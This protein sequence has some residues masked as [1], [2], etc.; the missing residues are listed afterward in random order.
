MDPRY[1]VSWNN[2]QAPGWAAADDQYDYGPLHRQQMIADRVRASIRGSH[3]ASLAQL[4]KSMEEPATEDLRAVKLLPVLRRAIGKPHSQKLRDALSTLMAWHRAGGHRRD[5]NGDGAYEH[6]RAVTVMDAWWPLLVRAEFEP[7]LGK[8]VY[9]QLQGM[10]PVGDHTRGDPVAPD[11]FSGWWGYVSKDLRDLF[12]GHPRGAYS[13]V[14]C[15][16]GSR[17]RCRVALRS[18]LRQAL[19]V[20]PS[21]L[22]GHGDCAGDPDAQCYDQN[23]SVITSAISIPPAPFQNRPTFQQTV[24][25]KRNLP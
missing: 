15:G 2:K 18:S 6:N 9:S 14:Y 19:K 5:L 8:K 3:K 12:G 4:V 13:R 10:L 25:V 24:S 20:S 22:Y 23:R 11:F 7:T 21:T 16:G 17:A 1:L